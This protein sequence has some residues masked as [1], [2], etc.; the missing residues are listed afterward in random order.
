METGTE[1]QYCQRKIRNTTDGWADPNAKGDD[2]LW[3][4]VCDE[5]IEDIYAHHEPKK[6]A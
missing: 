5:N 6:G 3:R 1:C 2:K 4:Y